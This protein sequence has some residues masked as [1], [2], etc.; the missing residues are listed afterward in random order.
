MISSQKKFQPNR[1]FLRPPEFPL[2]FGSD[3]FKG[4]KK[5][6]RLWGSWYSNRLAWTHDFNAKIGF[7]K[8]ALIPE[9]SPK[10]CQFL[11]VWFGRAILDTF[12]IISWDSV[13]IFQDQFLRWN[14]EA[15]P[16]DLNTMNP[17]IRTFIFSLL[18]FSR[19]PATTNL[20]KYEK[21]R[22]D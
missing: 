7:E 4:E 5:L 19:L 21:E 8:Y 22:I 13:H 14:R 12:L 1:S 2:K 11:L 6:F 18:V 10:M 3:P 16:V 9:I 15:K 20:L 17:M